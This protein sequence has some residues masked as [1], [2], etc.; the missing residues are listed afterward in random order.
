MDPRFP[1]SGQ[2]PA[3]FDVAFRRIRLIHINFLVAVPVYG[4]AGFLIKW[5]VMDAGSGFVDL[6]SPDYSI[7]TGILFLAA[8]ALSVIV[9]FVFPRQ[10]PLQNSKQRAKISSPEELWQALSAF[11]LARVAMGNSVAVFGLVLFLLNG[12]LLLLLVF[13]GMAFVLLALIFPRRTEWEEARRL[14]EDDSSEYSQ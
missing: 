8:I 7:L 9:L 13:A 6:P 5:F 11:Q 12:D 14:I 10:N 4:I 1:F 2:K 3:D